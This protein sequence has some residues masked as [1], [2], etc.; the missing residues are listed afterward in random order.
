[1]DEAWRQEGEETFS[2][3]S[4]TGEEKGTEDGPDSLVAPMFEH[5]S[6]GFSARNVEESIIPAQMASSYNDGKKGQCGAYSLEW[7]WYRW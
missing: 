3:E 5:T 1:L 7:G 4:V 2:S 6:D